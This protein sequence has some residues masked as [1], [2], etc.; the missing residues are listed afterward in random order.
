MIAQRNPSTVDGRE[1]EKKIRRRNDRGGND[2]CLVST[3]KVGPIMTS[4][5]ECY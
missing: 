2:Y 1:R 5:L 4:V 3:A